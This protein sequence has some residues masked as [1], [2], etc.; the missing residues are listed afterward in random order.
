MSKDLRRARHAVPV[1]E[2]AMEIDQSATGTIVAV[3]HCAP[4]TYDR[5][6]FSRPIQ[7]KGT[8][9]C[10]DIMHVEGQESMD[11]IALL[12]ITDAVMAASSMR[13]LGWTDSEIS[14]WLGA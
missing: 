9:Q 14:R 11:V 4:M 7:P 8:R 3:I 12:G 2:R 6:D 13:R 1:A 10:F 5:T